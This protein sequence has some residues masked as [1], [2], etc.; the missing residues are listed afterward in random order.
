VRKARILLAD[1]NTINQEVALGK[2]EQLGLTADVVANGL[3]VLEA[4]RRIPY[5]IVLMDCMM[6]E[7]D[8]LRAAWSPSY[9]R[10]RG[11][12]K[13]GNPASWTARRKRTPKPPTSSAGCDGFSTIMSTIVRPLKSVG[14]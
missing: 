5:D 6:P 13:W 9:R 14:T 1:D 11:W 4:M 3:E 8:G 10:S 12:S 7:M 2:L